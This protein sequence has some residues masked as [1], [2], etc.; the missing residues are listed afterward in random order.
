[1][2]HSGKHNR[3]KGTNMQKQTGSVHAIIIGILTAGLI[4]TLGF[5]FWQNFIKKDDSQKIVKS[6]TS[7]IKKA[8]VKP[9]VIK[10][11]YCAESE[12]LCFDYPENWT[13]KN[14]DGDGEGIGADNLSTTSPDK[15]VVLYLRTGMGSRGGAFPSP[16]E[17]P[18]T[19]V[20]VEPALK[21]GAMST[22]GYDNSTS[23]AYVSEVITSDL[24]AEYASNGMDIISTKI[25]GYYP[26][27]VLHNSKQLST[28]S[29]FLSVSE[30]GS[31]SPR[32]SAWGIDHIPGR[33][34]GKFDT[35]TIKFGS[36]PYYA[37]MKSYATVEE[38]K[39]QLKNPSF[40]QAKAILLSAHYE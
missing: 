17:G 3:S 26:V 2:I 38:A 21:I 20:N 15:S 12:K 16:P 22:E 33:Y 30:D 28:K 10:K 4:G 27:V 39:A 24:D 25:L 6:T 11:T 31:L 23:K 32:Y 40:E 36:S 37:K 1:M 14:P 7:S 29:T 18:V 9:P 34:T 5:I 19:V 8:E 13:I 35:A